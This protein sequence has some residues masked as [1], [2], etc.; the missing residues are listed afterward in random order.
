MILQGVVTYMSRVEARSNLNQMIKPFLVGQSRD[1]GG[2]QA[3]KINGSRTLV[4]SP[5]PTLSPGGMHRRGTRLHGCNLTFDPENQEPQKD[6]VI[7]HTLPIKHFDSGV[8][9]ASTGNM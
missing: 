3:V 4:L 6:Q 9:N 5:E 1:Q 8:A 2:L 7:K